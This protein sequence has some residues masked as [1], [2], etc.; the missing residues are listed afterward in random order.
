[1]F[2]RFFAAGGA[3]AVNNVNV[4]QY[5][6]N[7]KVYCC[8]GVN[9]SNKQRESA[10]SGSVVVAL[11]S[12]DRGSMPG[13]ERSVHCSDYSIAPCVVAYVHRFSYYTLTSSLADFLN[14][15]IMDTLITAINTSIQTV[16]LSAGNPQNNIWFGE[17][18]TGLDNGTFTDSYANGFLYVVVVI[19]V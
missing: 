1:M 12:S 16:R 8:N 13:R 15:T 2:F 5:V 14:P 18:A 7:F 10:S 4:H 11:H 19:I 17:T 6:A 3:S 9:R